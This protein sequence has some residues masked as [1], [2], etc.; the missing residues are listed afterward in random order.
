M[1]LGIVDENSDPLPSQKFLS[2]LSCQSCHVPPPGVD[3]STSTEGTRE[4]CVGCH[5]SEFGQ[6]L[7][8]WLD[9]TEERLAGVQGFLS[10]ARRTLG[11]TPALDS[12]GAR[13][14]LVQ[15][16]GAYHNLL[17]AHRVMEGA[18]QEI[19][20]A[21][22]AAGR[23]A[24]AGPTLGREPSMGVCSYC[25]YELEDPLVF[26]EMTGSFHREVREGRSGTYRRGG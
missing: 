9:G 18:T 20:A 11:D 2:G 25:H 19:Q 8:W 12:V 17:F 22:Q 15:T 5:R 4:S 23:S 24:P 10:Q 16:G 13:L 6:V 3:P 26:Q 7:D 1:I 14:E 21:Y